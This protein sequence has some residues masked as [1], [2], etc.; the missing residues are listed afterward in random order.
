M[1][2]VFATN[3]AHKLEEARRIAGSEYEILSL[4]DIGCHEELPETGDTIEAN[5]LQ[6]ASY[7]SEKYGVDCFSDDTG[8]FVEALNGRPGVYS[9]R[10]AG[11]DCDPEQNIDK[12]LEELSGRTDRDAAFRTVV[13]L[14]RLG[15]EPVAFEGRVEG[16]IADQRRGNG[17]FGY[18]PVFICKE[19]GISFAEMEAEEKNAL[20]HRGRALRKLFNFL[21]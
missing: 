8:L 10:Y 14:C 1:K 9:A 17:G 2:L 18:D 13:T 19:N 7:L 16:E 4:A 21:K 12:L 3:N 11:P 6:K 20:S 5:S 15:Q